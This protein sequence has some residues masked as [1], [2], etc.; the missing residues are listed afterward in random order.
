M[1]KIRTLIMAKAEKNTPASPRLQ[2]TRHPVVYEINTR[3][4]LH[5]LSQESGAAVTL[6]DIP[7]RILD[8]WAGLG[9]DAVWLM[10]AWTTGALGRELAMGAPG[11][12][13]EY[14]RSLPDVVP[15]DVIGSPYAVQEYRIAPALGGGRALRTLR[16]RLAKK[17]IGLILDYV[18]NHTARDHTWVKQHPEYYIHADPAL[19]GGGITDGFLAETVAG[20][21]MIAHGRDPMFPGWTDTAQ[22][23]PCSKLARTAMIAQLEEIADVCDGVR[24]DMA[25]L[26]LADVFQRTWGE[27]GARPEE[28]RAEGEFW[29]EAIGRVTES[30][31]GFLFIA[32]AYWNR[33]WD[34]QQL[35]FNYTYDK[36]LY[37]RLLREGASA[38]RDHLKADPLYQSRSLRFLENH[39]EERAARMLPS[40]PWQFAAA[41]IVATVPGMFLL[42]EGQMEA[43]SVRVPVQLRRRVAEVANARSMAFYE[44]LM[45]VIDHPVF[46]TGTWRLLSMH[47]AWNDNHT[48]HNFISYWWHD[49]AQGNRFVVVNYAPHSGQVYVDIPL[50]LLEGHVIEFRDLL[51]GATYSREK[52]A[53]H[54][55]GMYF[56]LPGYGIHVFEVAGG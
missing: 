3:V 42:H 36:T 50:D 18:S 17:G 26:L 1:V 5:E 10:G 29:R 56:D 4:L 31:P 40:E 13:E 14:R 41:T 55:K 15:E 8:E 9:V 37:D 28:D 33:E 39:D 34:L 38:V 46:Q 44:K 20:S 27:A 52:V 25:M 48:W 43:R 54:A 24:C 51:G 6:A 12:M 49:P 32:E 22:L 11:L 21:L 30:H 47:P 53:L 16:S 23:N 19:N 7:D 2:A 35:G 45:D